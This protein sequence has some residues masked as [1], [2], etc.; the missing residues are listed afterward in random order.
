LQIDPKNGRAWF[1]NMAAKAKSAGLADEG[2]QFFRSLVGLLDDEKVR[3][4]K[5]A[6]G[7]RTGTRGLPIADLLKKPDQF[8]SLIEDYLRAV[9]R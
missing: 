7:T 4:E 3:S 5:L 6:P 2:L 1:E 8:A 9:S